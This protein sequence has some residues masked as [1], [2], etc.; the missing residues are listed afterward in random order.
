MKIITT[1]YELTPE[2]SAVPLCE[3]AHENCTVNIPKIDKK[4]VDDLLQ[5]AD[6]Y[7]IQK[8]RGGQ[9]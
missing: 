6:F 4:S 1:T 8:M 5:Q 2:E 7:R 3:L 9:M